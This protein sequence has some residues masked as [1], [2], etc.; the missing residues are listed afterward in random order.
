M[1]RFDDTWWRSRAIERFK[2]SSS[3]KGDNTR[4]LVRAL[5]AI[6]DIGKVVNWCDKNNIN[7]V[8]DNSAGGKYL[9]GNVT[10]NFSL[11]PERQLHVLLHECGHH[12]IAEKASNMRFWRGYEEDDPTHK[13]T[14][15]HRIDVLHEEL[16]AWHEGLQLSERIGIH[17]DR[18]RYNVSRSVYVK[19][20]LKW[21]L[22]T[23][24]Y[25]GGLS[26]E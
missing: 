16:E 22:R 11:Y 2:C 12:V 20:Y 1:H 3:D 23:S 14:T 25:K 9:P 4:H 7:V 17:I 24:G 8:F 18:D 26:D 15:A 21:V 13:K 19:T 5:D 6:S 10:V